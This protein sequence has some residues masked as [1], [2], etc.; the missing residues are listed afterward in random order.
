MKLSF[1]LLLAIVSANS[2][3]FSIGVKAGVPLTDA[4]SDVQVA[5]GAASHFEDRYTVGPTAEVHLPF[6]LSFEV[7]AL[8]R[9]SGFGINGGHGADGNA[10]VNE[11]QI[12]LLG[13][14]EMP[15]GPVRPF[16]DAGVAYRHLSVGLSNSLSLLQTELAAQNPDNAGFVIGG[17]IGLKILHIRLSPEIRYTHWGQ[18]AFSNG[19]VLSTNNQADFLVGLTF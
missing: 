2:Q 11:W 5:D 16:I 18:T 15:L 17:G 6:H 12:P 4:Y 14:Y 7:D 13:K 1:L 9:H 10:S 3:V 8:Y 19:A